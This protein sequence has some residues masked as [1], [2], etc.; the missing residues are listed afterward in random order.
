[1]V[2][3]NVTTNS[4]YFYVEET[5]TKERGEKHVK[6]GDDETMSRLPGCRD[7]GYYWTNALITTPPTMQSS[8]IGT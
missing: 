8:S 4:T 7:V 6:N 5:H 1:M 2:T 3:L